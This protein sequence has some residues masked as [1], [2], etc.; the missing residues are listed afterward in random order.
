MEVKCPKCRFK[1]DVVAAPGI[2]SLA[3]ACPRCG[4]PFSYTIPDE[5]EQDV[6][7]DSVVEQPDGTP[8]QSAFQQTNNRNESEVTSASSD[9]NA[10]RTAGSRMSMPIRNTIHGADVPPIDEQQYREPRKRRSLLPGCLIMF[11]V[12]LI[13]AVFEIRS[14]N[15]R[16]HS[17]SSGDVMND[18]NATTTT[19]DDSET[20]PDT[21]TSKDD[22][23]EVHAEK[24]PDWIQG[25]WEVETEYGTIQIHIQGNKVTE[26][27]DGMK[28]SG[29]FYFE[30]GHLVCD[31]QDGSM[32]T[33]KV[34][35]ES[36]QI[37][38]GEGLY[39]H[40]VK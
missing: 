18:D 20:E 34:D 36:Q 19:T 9:V 30:K 21:A 10:G 13:I 15:S 32:L 22:F 26:I 11:V 39:M 28:S 35:D 6:T 27:A 16:D 8:N 3:C 23:K 25:K 38:A 12:L 24:A 33:Y 7:D 2:K 1:F 14:C 29:T 17:Y 37:D 31:Y 5:A 4:T 40:K